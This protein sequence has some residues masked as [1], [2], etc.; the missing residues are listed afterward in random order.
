MG[1]AVILHSSPSSIVETERAAAEIAAAGGKAAAVSL[2]L[3]DAAATGGLIA[4]AGALF[5]PL[6]L[7]VNNASIFEDDSALDF[8]V[9]GFDR[10]LAVNL[11]APSILARDF[12]GRRRRAPMPQSSTSSISASC[13]S[14]P[15]I[16]PTR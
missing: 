4:K 14:R 6:T 8:D 9:D 15:S 5:G 2:D 3:S 7:L 16:F 1:Y 10:R 13:G 12:V 11:R